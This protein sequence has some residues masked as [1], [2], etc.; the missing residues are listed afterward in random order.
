MRARRTSGMTGAAVCRIAALMAITAWEKLAFRTV[1]FSARAA[2]GC[3]LTNIDRE[4]DSGR[5][6]DTAY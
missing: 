4:D 2:L 6:N 1:L 3:G 5:Q